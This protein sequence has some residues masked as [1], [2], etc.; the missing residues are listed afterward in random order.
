MEDHGRDINL[1]I[2]TDKA[3]HLFYEF[4]KAE[5]GITQ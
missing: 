2:A 5:C 3:M 4:L 1:A